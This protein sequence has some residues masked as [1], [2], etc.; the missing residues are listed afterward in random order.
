MVV[1]KGCRKGG[2]KWLRKKNWKIIMVIEN[3][4]GKLAWKNSRGKIVVEKLLCEMI[5]KNGC[6]K[7][8]WK[9]RSKGD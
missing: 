6:G 1:E 5:V 9:N 2:G 7:W 3:G 4:C 8:L